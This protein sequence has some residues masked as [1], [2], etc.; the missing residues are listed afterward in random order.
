MTYRKTEIQQYAKI[1]GCPPKYWIPTIIEAIKIN[2]QEK[3]IVKKVKPTPH[4]PEE[5][6]L[7]QKKVLDIISF[8]D[9][10]WK[11]FEKTPKSYKS[12]W[13]EDLRNVLLVSLNSRIS[14]SIL[15]KFCLEIFNWSSI[16]PWASLLSFK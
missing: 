14:S 2:L 5:Y 1:C 9:N 7:D 6:S 13:E 12:M 8:L 10:Q 16:N 4:K 15:Y 3:S 11:Q